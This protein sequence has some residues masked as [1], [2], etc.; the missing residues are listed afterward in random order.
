[1]TEQPESPADD[2]CDTCGRPADDPDCECGY[3]LTDVD[4]AEQ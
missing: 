4:P 3:D 2:A 1:M